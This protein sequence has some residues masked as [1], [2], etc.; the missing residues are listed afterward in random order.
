[1]CDLASAPNTA[2]AAAAAAHTAA[3]KKLRHVVSALMA[4]GDEKVANREIRVWHGATE[5]GP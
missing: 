1:M 2:A 3:Q 5:K 4:Y